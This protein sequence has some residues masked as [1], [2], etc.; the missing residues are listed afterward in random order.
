MKLFELDIGSTKSILSVLQGQSSKGGS[1]GT[2]SYNA[3]MNLFKQFDL[4]LGG[5]NSDKQKIITALK[6][7]IDPTGDVIKTV[8]PDG[9]IVLNNPNDAASAAPAA[10]GGST[11]DQMASQAANKAINSKI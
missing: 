9:S 10:P 2:I 6:N 4:P 3:V 8:N 11:V 7:T 1:S 5:P